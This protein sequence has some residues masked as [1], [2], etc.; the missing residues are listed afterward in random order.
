MDQPPRRLAST[1]LITQ[2]LNTE[3]T[4]VSI[5]DE[6]V[7][8]SAGPAAI[9]PIRRDAS[10]IH[11]VMDLQEDRGKSTDA[12]RL[13]AFL[14]EN[15][16]EHSAFPRPGMSTTRCDA[17]FRS[18]NF[19]LRFVEYLLPIVAAAGK[20]LIGCRDHRSWPR[21]RED[22]KDSEDHFALRAALNCCLSAR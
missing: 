2:H 7:A 1:T 13:R 14:A 10:L 8:A 3:A 16:G 9:E 18:S 17:A 11:H 5:D 21:K 4:P 6:G 12:P 20:P 22:R 15:I 19:R